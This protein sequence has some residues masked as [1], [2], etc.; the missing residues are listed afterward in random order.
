MK[1]PEYFDFGNATTKIVSKKRFIRKKIVDTNKIIQ[2]PKVVANKD[3][4]Y[5]PTYYEK[6]RSSSTDSGYSY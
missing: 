6:M 5:I 4:D 1:V 3:D 2:Q